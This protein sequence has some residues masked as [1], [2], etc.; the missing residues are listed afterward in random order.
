MTRWVLR[1]ETSNFA[2]SNLKLGQSLSAVD[3][4]KFKVGFQVSRCSRLPWM[5]SYFTEAQHEAKLSG[6]DIIFPTQVTGECNVPVPVYYTQSV[7]PAI[8]QGNIL[9]LFYYAVCCTATVQG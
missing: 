2:K 9:M 8:I 3:R 1:T 6:R 5:P 4:V 7:V